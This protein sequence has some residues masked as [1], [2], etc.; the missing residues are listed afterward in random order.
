MTVR[1]LNVPSSAGSALLDLDPADAVFLPATISAAMALQERKLPAV[2]SSEVL[3]P[4]DFH[5]IWELVISTVWAAIES[6]APVTGGTTPQ[7]MPIFGYSIAI[8]LA[9]VLALARL[10]DGIHARHGLTAVRVDSRRGACEY[11][12]G[13]GDDDIF[14]CEVAAIWAA[15]RGIECRQSD[16]AAPVSAAAPATTAVGAKPQDRSLRGRMRRVKNWATRH[17]H[18]LRISPLAQTL[19]A[20]GSVLRGR[21]IV[22][23]T[24]CAH[25]FPPMRQQ[26]IERVAVV[27]FAG[28]LSLLPR[29][30]VAAGAMIAQF[31]VSPGWRKIAAIAGP[32]EAHLLQRVGRRLDGLWTDG[33][34]MYRHATHLARAIRACG[35]TPVIMSDSA[36]CDF[37]PGSMG[38]AAEAFRQ[39]GGKIAEIQHGGN[40]TCM[41][42]GFTPTILTTGL[43]H[44]FLEWNDLACREHE[45]YRLKPPRLKFATVGCWSTRS[46]PAAGHP[47]P[48]PDDRRIRVLY[49]PT[50][51]STAT[52][53]GINALWDD[54][55]LA[56]DRV[57]G[58]LD[59]SG[60]EVDVSIIPDGEMHEFLSRR[61]YLSLRF[62][63]LAF[64]R[65]AP[66]ADV[67]IAD[68]LAGSPAYESTMTDKP[69]IVLTGCKQ[70]KADRRFMQDL[71]RRCITYDDLDGY[72]EGLSDFVANPR[73]YLRRNARIVDPAVM[74][75]YFSP[76]DAGR[77]WDAVTGLADG[78]DRARM[79]RC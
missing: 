21:S 47:L 22:L 50:L 56:L 24:N 13:S 58:L 46:V 18:R 23:L 19:V 49:A 48:A 66:Q 59:R 1:T 26:D 52:I 12:F 73:E 42:R 38:F 40:Y 55:V 61:R 79:S 35:G 25:R 9:Q 68:M 20:L 41:E 62:H 7:L 53:G 33:L 57:L 65:L 74:M 30:P 70:F 5:A 60:M 31:R 36:F 77:F 29:R 37:N 15:S 28:H 4:R 8:A 67:L 32:F 43:G 78:D 71:S 3:E 17:A 2:R 16:P 11:V 63:P 69:A 54:Y 10:L 76:I 44:L 64:G 39:H 34:G 14:Y 72:I 27:P 45:T 75:A 6:S 51:L